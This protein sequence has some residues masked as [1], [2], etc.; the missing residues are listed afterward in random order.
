MSGHRL[1]ETESM[2]ASV[3]ISYRV[4]MI[5]LVKQTMMSGSWASSDP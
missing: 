4:G 1:S 2:A 3:A 5:S